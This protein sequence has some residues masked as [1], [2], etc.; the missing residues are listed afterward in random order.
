MLTNNQQ[1]DSIRLASMKAYDM[2]QEA[3]GLITTADEVVVCENAASSIG[4][5]PDMTFAIDADQM[6]R[7]DIKAIWHSHIN[8]K[9]VFSPA[10][11]K[12]CRKIQKP[13]VLH[14]LLNDRWR[15]ADPS[16]DAPILGAEFTYGVEDCYKV[17][18]RYYWQ[19]F[20]IRLTDYERSDLFDEVGNYIFN[21]AGWNE[22][23]RYFE[24][25]GFQELASRHI[26]QQGDLLLMQVGGAVNAN[27][28]AIVDD[29]GEA[30]F[31]HQL[32]GRRAEPEFW[33]G[34][35]GYWKDNTVAILRRPDFVAK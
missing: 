3:C 2:R 28:I 22:F 23:R 4:E 33:Y 35:S 29:P 13:F 25:E 12:A 6:A 30:I 5:S 19:K 21:T 1:R 10:D 16:Y 32:L 17:V 34:D 27:H 20:Q 31:F 7:R 18:C 26:L 15:E 11:V 14:D 24:A 9:E 8:G